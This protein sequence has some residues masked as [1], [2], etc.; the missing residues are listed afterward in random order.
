LDSDDT[1]EFESPASSED[2]GDEEMVGKGEKSIKIVE[3][4]PKEESSDE[5]EEVKNDGEFLWCVFW[6]TQVFSRD[7]FQNRLEDPNQTW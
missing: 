7:Y 4:K 3:A 6:W 1:D 2:E 5:E